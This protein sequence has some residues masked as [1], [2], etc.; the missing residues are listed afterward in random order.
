MNPSTLED[1]STSPEDAL[2]AQS[3]PV[4]LPAKRICPAV[5]NIPGVPTPGDCFQTNL[6]NTHTDA[7]I[8]TGIDCIDIAATNGA[9][10][11]SFWVNRTT[12]FQFPQGMLVANGFTTVV[13]IFPSGLLSPDFTH[14]VGDADPA[15]PNII[16]GT[17]QFRD[18]SGDVRL[19][20]IVNL[21]A[22]PATV[23]FNCIFV[24]DLD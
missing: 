22:F 7:L 11:P 9:V 8:G 15:V 17:G 18:A 6:F 12:I 20:G 24:I 5:V 10:D 23:G 4:A 13:P 21:S 14:V 16:Y 2:N 19:S 1:Q 3:S